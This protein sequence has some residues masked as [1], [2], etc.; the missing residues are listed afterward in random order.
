M[1][2]FSESERQRAIEIRMNLY[3]QFFL[4]LLVFQCEALFD[5]STI[6]LF[7]KRIPVDLLADL[8]D[9]IAGRQPLC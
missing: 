9:F 5:V 3:L 2:R 1:K 8:N 6:T 4:S 7:R